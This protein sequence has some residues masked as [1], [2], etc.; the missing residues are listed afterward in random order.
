MADSKRILIVRPSALGDVC[1]TVPVLA[2]LRRA[3]PEAVIDW[4]VQ[5][6]FAAAI[7]AHPALD[8]AVRFPRQQFAR[9]WRSPA[10]ARRLA[11][12]LADLGRR[13]YDLVI[14]CQGL[15]R[16]GLITW[17]TR[18][19]R[20][21]GPRG[22]RELGWLGYTV[23]HP[24]PRAA[25]TVRQMM[26]LLVAEGLEPVYDMRLYAAE[27]DRA[28]W[29]A[30]R[31]ELGMAGGAYAV[32]APTTRWPSKRWPQDRWSQL[33]EPLAERGL[34]RVV[35]IGAPSELSQVRQIAERAPSVINLVGRATVGRTMAV[36]ADAD[37][38]VANDSAPL[39]MAVGFQRPCVGL[40]GPTDPTLVG[41][42]GADHAVV[43]AGGPGPRPGR[44]FRDP[45]LGDALMRLIDAA[46]VQQRIDRV[47]DRAA[48]SAGDGGEPGWGARPQVPERA[49]S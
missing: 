9:W 18:A 7:E 41:P 28:W 12:W 13:R 45:K 21:V 6:E 29:A 44:R 43:R 4:L 31:A 23:R 1:R 5:D 16:S 32:L 35:L 34:R 15:S 49:A 26:S 19:R 30:Q 39:H 2:T 37:L 20:R 47:L 11:G 38:V 27:A 24:V 36:I 8:E 46:H 25:H 40:Y 48:R 3:W 14:D 33:I 42:W 10:V 17:A 22:A